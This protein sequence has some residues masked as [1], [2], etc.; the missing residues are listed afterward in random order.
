MSTWPR[1]GTSNPVSN[2]RL[3]VSA[4][5]RADTSATMSASTTLPAGT[6]RVALTNGRTGLLRVPPVPVRAV[7]V[8]LHGAGG[9]AD[10]ALNLL[11]PDADRLGLVV[12]APA[13]FGSTWAMLR[14]GA[15]VD[16]AALDE[17]LG[18][19]L[20]ALT[21]PDAVAVAG[22]S[23]GASYALA[24]GLA[25]GDLFGHVLAFSPGF[26]AADRRQGR[27]R[28]FV[29]HGVSD[30]VLPIARTSRR[31]VPG[32]HQEGYEVTYREFDG[33]H[34]VPARCVTEAVEWM[35]DCGAGQRPGAD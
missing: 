7:V 15:D 17:A 33:G 28:F 8:A 30:E 3:H 13:S 32:L 34:V 19:V 20:A 24:L 21:P 1:G 10:Q 14:G 31:I 22:F 29:S 16:T 35:L 6:T 12:L 11:R 18:D 25:N 5:P 26:H 27:P 4:R 23:D 9:R 2:S